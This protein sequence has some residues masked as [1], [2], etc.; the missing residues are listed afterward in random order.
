MFC[1]DLVPERVQVRRARGS[2]PG[3]EAAAGDHVESVANLTEVA[4]DFPL[5]DDLLDQEAHHLFEL[6]LVEE[7]EEVDLAELRAGEM[8][9]EMSVFDPGPASA[10]VKSSAAC[11]LWFIDRS[12]FA[13]CY[14]ARFIANRPDI[15]HHSFG[16]AADINIFNTPDD[17]GNI[18]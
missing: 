7:A 16:A 18:F 12:A 2:A 10:D 8:F 17:S 13:G 4:N 1:N 14:N 3:L 11:Q 15:S 9:G 6:L 5:L